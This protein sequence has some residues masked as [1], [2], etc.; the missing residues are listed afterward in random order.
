MHRHSSGAAILGDTGGSRMDTCH[1]CTPSPVITEALQIRHI[2]IALQH[3]HQAPH[4]P[5]SLPHSHISTLP[6]GS[7]KYFPSLLFEASM[8]H[9]T[10]CTNHAG[11][12]G[13]SE[14]TGMTKTHRNSI[15]TVFL[16]ACFFF[17]LP[18]QPSLISCFKQPV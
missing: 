5:S 8:G 2:C 9:G 4:P 15:C 17:F 7:S 11:V 18:R 1:L 3:F 16:Q 12:G 14:R 13:G 10:S 6:S